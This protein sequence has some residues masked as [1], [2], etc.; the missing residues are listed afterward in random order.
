MWSIASTGARAKKKICEKITWR[1][2]SGWREFPTSRFWTG[3]LLPGCESLARQLLGA[4]GLHFSPSGE[5]GPGLALTAMRWRCC[6][7]CSVWRAKAGGARR[8][9]GFR[10]TRNVGAPSKH[11]F[12]GL[13]FQDDCIEPFLPN[14]SLL[15]Y[16]QNG[17]I[18][19]HFPNPLA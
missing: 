16:L 9:H 11:S 19:R 4:V 2:E 3:A 1:G 5:A 8:G 18:H 7:P 6:C 15:S 13:H 17:E 14:P 10:G 12:A